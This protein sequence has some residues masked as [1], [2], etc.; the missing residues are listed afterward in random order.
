MNKY[1][2]TLVKRNKH[3]VPCI[4]QIL[5]RQEAFQLWPMLSSLSSIGS[6]KANLRKTAV[7]KFNVSVGLAC[8]T[9]AA[10]SVSQPC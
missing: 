4:E 7:N 2:M 3:L 5:R 10:L 9:K 1:F 8:H 6:V